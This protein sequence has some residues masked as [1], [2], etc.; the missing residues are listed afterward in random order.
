MPWTGCTREWRTKSRFARRRASARQSSSLVTSRGRPM[1][2]PCPCSLLV[3][4]RRYIRPDTRRARGLPDG[5][6]HHRRPAH[7]C[8]AVM[9]FRCRRAQG[10]RRAIPSRLLH[11]RRL[12]PC[13]KPAIALDVAGERLLARTSGKRRVNK[14]CD[15]SHGNAPLSA[16]PSQTDT[17]TGRSRPDRTYHTT[18]HDRVVTRTREITSYTTGS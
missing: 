16:A 6:A 7:V 11:V 1:S 10:A 3:H 5:P 2:P 15:P 12:G 13:S 9:F 4:R 8:I 14:I 17:G 18:V